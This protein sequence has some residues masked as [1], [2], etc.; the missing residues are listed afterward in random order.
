MARRKRPAAGASAGAAHPRSIFSVE[1]VSVIH[2]LASQGWSQREIAAR[3]T[4]ILIERGERSA[5]DPAIR[6][7]V[8]GKVLRAER[9]SED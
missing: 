5:R 1:D 4:E 9:H 3:L 6:H 7:T 2:S 8:I